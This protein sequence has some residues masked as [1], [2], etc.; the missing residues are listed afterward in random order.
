MK[1]CKFTFETVDEAVEKIRKFLEGVCG[2]KEKSGCGQRA[3]GWL[4][5]QK[6][7]WTGISGI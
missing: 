7:I 1:E 5:R 6:N 2:R 3:L 4:K